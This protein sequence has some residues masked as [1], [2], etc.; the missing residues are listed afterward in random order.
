VPQAANAPAAAV[1]G[2]GY[3][4]AGTVVS[5]ADGRP[6]A[7]ARITVRDTKDSKKFQSVVTSEDGKYE[8]S[9][10]TEGKYSLS[11]ARRG[12]I[13]ASYDQHDQYSTAIVTGAG[14]TTESLVLL[15]APNAVIAGR[16]MD[17]IN[18]PV[19]NA[20]VTLYYDDHSS[21]VDQI[22]HSASSQTNDLGEYEFIL[23]RPGTYFLSASATPWYAVHP[24]SEPTKSEPGQSEP[25]Q[26]DR[27]LD[28]AYPIT[29]Y[30]DVTEADD[31]MPIPIRGGERLQADIHLNPV[32]SLHLLFRMPGD[33]QHGYNFPQLEQPSFDG[34]ATV[35]QNGGGTVVSP[36]VMEIT[37]IPAG[38]YNLRV[39]QPGSLV[40]MN[41][42]DF[43]KDGEEIDI[44]KSEAMSNVKVSVEIPGETLPAQ[45]AV[46]LR[47]GNRVV[48]SSQAIDSKGQAELQQ[49]PVGRYEVVVFGPGKPYSIRR[50]S[51]EGAI[52]S[53]HTLNV[54]AG[55]SPSVS[56][57]LATGSVEIQG[58]VKLAGKGFAGAM[59]VLVPMNPELDRDLFRRDQSDLDGTFS[60]KGVV[61]GS[62]TVLAIEDGWEL[63]W[64][65]PAVIAAYLKR[66]QKVTV[67]GQGGRPMTIADPIEVQSK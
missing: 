9:G 54:T 50:I 14:L 32:P 37:G 38:R 39:Y 25:P 24:H 34:S 30:P 59:V 16:V 19:R 41:G 48:T 49:V 47:S 55:S 61:P 15:L 13:S 52:V 40:Q 44:S 42:I 46:V 18:E 31:A 67:A 65:Q 27:S 51:A 29:Y 7:R 11:G 2:G 64:S 43:T 6:L 63:N 1:S 5:K 57:T 23:F 20:E 35:L 45:L 58:M 12:F 66:G 60:L 28:V 33:G 26:I 3:R 10:L 17:E 56:L 21:G 36:G 4:I 8:F 53:G 22:R 62:Y